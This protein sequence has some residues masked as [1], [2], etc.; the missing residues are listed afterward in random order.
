MEI[1]QL[2]VLNL[3]HS[4][5]WNPVLNVHGIHYVRQLKANFLWD[6]KAFYPGDV[7][8]FPN[9][10]VVLP[11]PLLQNLSLALPPQF[12]L[13]REFKVAAHLN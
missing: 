4:N 10:Q 2:G 1:E 8:A 13:Y 12:R 6:G 7:T 5:K 11:R 9:V 3:L